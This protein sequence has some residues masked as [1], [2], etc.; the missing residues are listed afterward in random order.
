MTVR[1]YEMRTT[2]HPKQTAIRAS[3]FHFG[4]TIPDFVT[5][6]DFQLISTS[7]YEYCAPPISE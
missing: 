6:R 5:N 7:H 4:I 3:G 1:C 2:A